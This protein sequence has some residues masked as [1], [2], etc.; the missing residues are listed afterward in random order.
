MAIK[1]I[2]NHALHSGG[3]AASV[4]D[5]VEDKKRGLVAR[6]ERTGTA[7]D[8]DVMKVLGSYT[9]PWVWKGEAE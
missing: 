5:V 2:Y 1:R 8:E 9:H 7:S 6:L 3:V 4:A